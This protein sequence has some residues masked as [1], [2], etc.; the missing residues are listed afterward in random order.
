MKFAESV[1]PTAA[2]SGLRNDRL[3]S[4]DVLRGL[5][6]LAVVCNHIPHYAIGGFRNNPWFF[7]A[8]AMDFGYLGVPLFVVIS[9]FCIHRRAAI[10]KSRGDCQPPDWIGFWKRRFWR[11]YPPYVVA[12]AFSFICE[13]AISNKSLLETFDMA[14]LFTHLFLVHN[15]TSQYAGGLGNGAFWSLGME[16]QLYFLYIPLVF[17]RLRKSMAFSVLIAACTTLGW[18][19]LMGSGLLPAH[20]CGLGSWSA[21]P[22]SFWMHW[23]L[24]ALAVE[25][26][27][28]VCRL[29][30]WCR[31]RTLAIIVLSLGMVTNQLTFK[32]LS[33]TTPGRQIALN[34]EAPSFALMSHVGE[35]LFGV[36]F[37]IFLNHALLRD[38]RGNGTSFIS[39]LVAGI[40]KISYSVYLIHLPVIHLIEKYFPLSHSV[41]DW[42]IR[43]AVCVS[44]SLLAGMAF[45]FGVERWFLS[46][47]KNAAIS[48]V[49]DQSVVVKPG[50]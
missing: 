38:L 2:D 50:S 45:Y 33:Q 42:P 15:L 36:A 25:A 7:P 47:S 6:I 40:G 31:S 22:F 3:Q 29:P 10:R 1:I 44:A 37:F 26:C 19:V 18:R 20:I 46:P 23:A 49:A 48:S 9:G 35:L 11:L 21:W 4:V 8:L 30:Q 28:G 32:F 14:D 34:W 41:Q 43:L 39:R 16:E 13:S 12:I 5:A 24:G 27:F 17:L